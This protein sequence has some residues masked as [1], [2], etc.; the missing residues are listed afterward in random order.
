VGTAF[1]LSRDSCR[2]QQTYV[3]PQ[4]AITVFELLMMSGVS[5][6]TR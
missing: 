2:Q 5:F 4:A 3:K 6:E 1:P